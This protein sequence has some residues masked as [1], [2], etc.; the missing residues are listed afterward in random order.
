MFVV[1]VTKPGPKVNAEDEMMTAAAKAAQV[2]KKRHSV[3]AG[4]AADPKNVL[5]VRFFFVC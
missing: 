5:L 4:A 2:G 3:F 1:V